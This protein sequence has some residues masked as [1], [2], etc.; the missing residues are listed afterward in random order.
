MYA[1]VNGF[2]APVVVIVI[3]V[4]FGI[5][6]VMKETPPMLYQVL[7]AVVLAEATN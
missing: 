2:V 5:E 3:Q 4:V 6:G 1:V 7:A